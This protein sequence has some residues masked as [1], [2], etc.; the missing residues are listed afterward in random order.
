[1]ITSTLHGP[2]LN[3]VIDTLTAPTALRWTGSDP[4]HL[5]ESV[6]KLDRATDWTSFHAALADWTIP[7][8]NFVYA[9]TKGNIGYQATGR[10][11]IRAKGNGL[12]PVDG[13]SGAYDWTGDVPYDKMPSVYNPPQGYLVTA[14][15]RVVGPDYP[16]LATGWWFPPYRAGRI[17]EMIAAK[18]KL[19]ID[20]V[21]A[22]QFDTHSVP[23]RAVGAKLAGLTGEG[24]V[25]EAAA[26]FKD[27][28]GDIGVDSAT[29]ALY[30]ITYQ[31]IQT[32][33]FSGQLGDTLAGEYLDSI[34]G[35]A[36]MLIQRALDDP[37][38]AL[39]DDSRTPA[40]ESR[41]DVFRA[42]LAAAVTILKAAQGDDMS[43]WSWG[44]MHQIVF[45]HSVFGAIA[46][47]DSIFNIGPFPNGGDRTTVSVGSSREVAPGA[48]QFL[49]TG[50]P[51]M[52]FVQDPGDWNR[53]QLVFAPGESGQPG[54]AH[55]GDQ[56]DAWLHGPHRTLPWTDD[57][58]KAVGEGTLTLQP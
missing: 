33:T 34:S 54:S 15:N 20:D 42:S 11:P 47:L 30:E 41:D 44:A 7:G 14:N 49:Q 40:H 50:H 53:T 3:A 56:A 5:L 52:R 4:G 36:D 10:W 29:A 16:Y 35:G 27:W 17:A 6:F 21:K 2:L 19:S 32:R 9:D 45:A 8:Q 12:V 28:D 31:E 26:R 18:P 43:K 58:I 25:T 22:M 57:A 38:A 46:P 55:W 24:G 23:A 13:A 37:Q 48:H 51:S 1:V 39:W